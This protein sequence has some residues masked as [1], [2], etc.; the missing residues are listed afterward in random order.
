MGRSASHSKPGSSCSWPRHSQIRFEP[1]EALGC[2]RSE[3][4]S[5]ADLVVVIDR[6]DQLE[7]IRIVQPGELWPVPPRHA[8]NLNVADARRSGGSCR[9][10]LQLYPYIAFVDLAVTNVELHVR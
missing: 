1:A 2:D 5:A 8:G 4:I 7:Q 9:V 10:L 3:P 6:I